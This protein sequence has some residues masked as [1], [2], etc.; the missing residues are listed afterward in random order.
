MTNIRLNKKQNK[1]QVQSTKK[2]VD[3]KHQEK[4]I[5]LQHVGRQGKEGPKGDPGVGIPTGGNDGDVLYK[6]G[7]GNYEVRWA[8]PLEFSD[9]HFVAEFIVTST[10]AVNHNLNKYPSVAVMDTAGEE[11]VGQVEY[12]NTNQ[13]VLKFAAPFSGRI[14]CN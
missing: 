14:N 1:I 7:D 4:T 2:R 12:L 11:V 13:L 9:K 8:A 6:N 3:L 10:V 5:K